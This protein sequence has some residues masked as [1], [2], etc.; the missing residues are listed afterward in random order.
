VKKKAIPLYLFSSFMIMSNQALFPVLPMIRDEISVSYS[1][2]SIFV[3]SLGIVRLF[4]AF[5]CGFLA[6]RFDK[7]NLFLLGG[8]LN[9]SGLVFLSYSHTIFQLI[10]SRILIGAGLVIVNITIMVVLAQMAGPN[11]KGAMI[12][13]NNVIHSAGGIISPALAGIL[14]GRYNW[15]LPFLVFAG[16]ILL[17]MIILAETFTDQRSDYKRPKDVGGMETKSYLRKNFEPGILR[18]APVFAISFF[19]FFYRSSFRHTLIPLY[20]KD[21]FHIGVGTLGLYISLAGFV[22]IFSVFAF[23]FMSDRYGR[24]T[25]LIPGM[26]FSTVA[27]IALFLPRGLNPLLIACIFTGM[28]AII[29]SIPIIVISDL[30]P[31]G[32]FGR[33]M[34][35]NRIFGDSGYFLGPLIVGSLMDQFG[36]RMPLYMLAGF[37]VFALI[38]ACFLSTTD[39]AKTKERCET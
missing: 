37:S 4:L 29:N 23:G 30:V 17:S 2:I 24:K 3:A 9:V 34:G 35:I 12:S 26:L 5:P 39:Q 27:V 13:M 10:V 8:F 6:D 19:V 18:L 22:A 38:V 36:F 33:I 21:V 1:Q 11:S 14:A 16:L 32:S 20:G 31:P 28:G 15:R 25:A 7:K